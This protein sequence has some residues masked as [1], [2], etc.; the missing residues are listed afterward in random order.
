MARRNPEEG[1]TSS[2]A[3]RDASGETDERDLKPGE[4]RRGG[5]DVKKG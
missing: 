1:E 2:L 4:R 3:Q 5:Q